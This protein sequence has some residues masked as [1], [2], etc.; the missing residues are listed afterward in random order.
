MTIFHTMRTRSAFSLVELIVVVAILAIVAAL[1]IPKIGSAGD[2][3]AIAAA[4]ILK[5][6]L[7][8]TRSLALTTQQTHSLVFSS[9]RQSYK[10]VA[11]Y[12][13]GDYAAA[14]AVAHPVLAQQSFTVT[15][16]SKNGMS[17]VTVVSASFGGAAYVTFSSQGEPSSAGTV[18]LRSGSTQ[19]QVSIEVLTGTVTVTRTAG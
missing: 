5:S 10:V 2:S 12:T 6:D 11:N 19:M 7:E 17:G 16:A 14:T 9:D 15:L 4:T 1:V 13:G 3:Q 18:T 8:V